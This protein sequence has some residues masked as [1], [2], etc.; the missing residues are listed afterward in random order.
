MYRTPS[1]PAS[2]RRTRL[3]GVSATSSS[4]SSPAGALL[5]DEAEAGTTVSPSVVHNPPT[6]KSH[7]GSNE[8][9]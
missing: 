1:L 9:S 3:L 5:V 7:P 6:L 4:L 2:G 8:N